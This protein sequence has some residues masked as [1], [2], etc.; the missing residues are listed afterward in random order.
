MHRTEQEMGSHLEDMSSLSSK[1]SYELCGLINK[2]FCAADL[3]YQ[4]QGYGLEESTSPYYFHC[5]LA[6][7]CLSVPLELLLSDP[8]MDSGSWTGLDAFLVIY[9]IT[10]LDTGMIAI[11]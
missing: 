4:I 1:R 11:G 7:K 10:F 6:A 9:W 3:A 5:K 2:H 8:K